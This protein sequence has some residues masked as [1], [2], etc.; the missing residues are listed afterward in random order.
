MPKDLWTARDAEHSRALYADWAADYD[1]D[2]AAADYATPDRVAAALAAHLPDRA[3]PILDFGCG[4][5]LS[6]AALRRAGFETVDGTDITPE[7]LE[8]ARGKGI[9]RA[10][11]VGTPGVAPDLASYAA[12]VATGVIGMGAAPASTLPLLMGAMRPGALLAFSYN[13]ATLRDPEC[14][15]TLAQVQID[16]AH[17]LW[18]ESGPHLPRQDGARISTV[19]ILRRA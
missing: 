16:G 12:I 1:A 2:L 9:Y 18:A 4:T 14:M 8:V 15:K 10:L 7:M 6:G 19:H 3:A 11:S 13:E 17:L 5:G